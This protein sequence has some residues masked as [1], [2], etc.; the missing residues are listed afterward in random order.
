MSWKK[1]VLAALCALSLIL[2]LSPPPARASGD[3]IFIALNEQV[4]KLSANTMPIWYNNSFF[5]PY[6][7]FDMNYMAANFGVSVDLGV[8]VAVGGNTVMLY[9]KRRQLI[10]D[11]EAGTCTDSQG[12]SYRS[13]IS[14]GG[15]TY[16]PIAAVQNFFSES[17]LLYTQRDTLY[18]TLLRLTTPSVVLSDD[19]F[20]DAAELSALPDRLREYNRGQPS[21]PSPSPSQPSP[22]PSVTPSPSQGPEQR[23][24]RVQ[25]SFVVADGG[26][27]AA[28]LDLLDRQSLRVLFLLRPED[29]AEHETLIRRMVGSGHALGLLLPGGPAEDAKERLREG[30]RLLGLIARVNT[31]TVA[32]E[33]GDQA[34]SVAMEEAGW[35]V[36]RSNVSTPTASSAS[37]YSSSLL[38]SVGEKETVARLQL[39][40]GYLIRTALPFLLESLRD[41][42]YDLRLPVGGEL[43]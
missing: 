6:V 1:S 39:S 14:R 18:G 22:S 30:N 27:T 16:L 2:G 43:D 28:L 34:A 5:V 25:L 42:K 3:V 37:A 17:G 12:N 9:D 10:Y 13:A 33:N 8:R 32:L 31:R 38:R 4:L 21:S 23:G 11:L 41:E 36:W 19:I 40:D 35:S 7:I 20:I 29:L 26:E 15:V 24:I